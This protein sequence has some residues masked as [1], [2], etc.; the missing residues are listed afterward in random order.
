MTNRRS[1]RVASSAL[2]VLATLAACG[3]SSTSNDSLKRDLDLAG[4]TSLELAP[5]SAGTNVV[6]AIEETPGAVPAKSAAKVRAPSNAPVAHKPVR[7]ASVA[8]ATER[9]QEQASA[10]QETAASQLPATPAPTPTPVPTPQRRGG[11]KSIGD[12]I[13]NAPFPINP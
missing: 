12:V 1:R 11:Y 4:S 10:P 3:R 13:R 5:R 7:R 9:P 8:A 2:V 6:S